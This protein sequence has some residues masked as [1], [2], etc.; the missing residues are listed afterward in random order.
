MNDRHCAGRDIASQLRDVT[1]IAADQ[2]PVLIS[3]WRKPLRNMSYNR[4]I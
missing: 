3:L 1:K 4:S 2:L